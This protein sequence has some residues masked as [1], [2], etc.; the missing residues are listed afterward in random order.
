M[1]CNVLKADDID[2]GDDDE[3]DSDD[4]DDDDGVQGPD[5]GKFPVQCAQSQ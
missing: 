4:D 2:A 1:Q 5:R 3:E